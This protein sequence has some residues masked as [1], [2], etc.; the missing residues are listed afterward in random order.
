[1]KNKWVFDR[2]TL[3]EVTDGDSLW[4]TV[5]TGF[6]HAATVHIRLLGV[7]CP[8]RKDPEGW[9]LA[10][11]FAINWLAEAGKITLECFGPDKY[12]RRWLG[13]ILNNLGESLSD[14]LIE[15]RVGV[16]YTGGKRP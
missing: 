14:A 9:R 16:P 11:G 5:D 2:C 6:D 15:S 7:D 8:E 13:R 10:R 1:M 12:G 4:I 3:A